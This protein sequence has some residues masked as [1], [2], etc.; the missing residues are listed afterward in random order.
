MKKI[1]TILGARP[2]FVKAAVLSR[3]IKKH[4]EI[5]EVII[6]TGQH[7]DANMS[8]VFF[9]EMEIPK[10]KYNLNING[11]SH[12]AMTGQML[13]K[14]EEVLVIEKPNVVVVFGDTNSTLAGALAAKKLH[15]KVA[16]VEAG[17]RSF[18]TKMPEEINRI[19][20][21]RISDVLLCPT[22][23]AVENLKNEGFKNFNAKIVQ[24]GDIMKDAVEFY[25]KTSKEKS[26]IISDL[27]LTKNEFVLA[28][29]HRQENTDDIEKLTSIFK[30]LEQISKEKKVVLPLHP[31]TKAILKKNKLNFNIKTIDPVGYFDMLELLK[32][33][34]LV[35]T[36][37][38]GLQKEAFFNKKHCIIAR[39]ETEWVELV[40]N[41]FAKIIKSNQIEM[42]KAFREFTQSSKKFNIKLYGE[43]V[44]EEVYLE[45][46]NIC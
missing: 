42:L 22:S 24:C 36:D 32:N 41:G 13:E 28:T 21:D 26:T 14:I 11:L 30:G 31:R 34:N 38:G 20:T 10:P 40:E 44:G 8:T 9:E 27:D 29:I 12:G 16:H 45:L 7:Y 23:V 3:V 39:D 2:Q 5:E 43:N 33:C 46:L 4:A 35:V 19:L 18:N 15:I 25:S 6:H 1:V 37:S 17:L